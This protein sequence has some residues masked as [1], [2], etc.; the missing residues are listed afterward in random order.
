[1]NLNFLDGTVYRVKNGKERICVCFSVCLSNFY[2]SAT[3]FRFQC[4]TTKGGEETMVLSVFAL[5][6]IIAVS[7]I[8]T[9]L[10]YK[11]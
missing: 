11:T 1:M 10:K 5:R 9:A 6:N 2:L 8:P 4:L 7:V 3:Y